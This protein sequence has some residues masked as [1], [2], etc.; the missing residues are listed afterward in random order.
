VPSHLRFHRG[1]GDLQNALESA[2][3]PAFFFVHAALDC[4][5]AAWLA[6]GGAAEAVAADAAAAPGLG[7][8]GRRSRPDDGAPGRGEGAPR[9]GGGGERWREVY[10]ELQSALVPCR[11]AAAA[12]AAAARAAPSS[13][14]REPQQQPWWVPA[15]PP[16]ATPRD[17]D[18]GG[19]EVADLLAWGLDSE[20]EFGRLLGFVACEGAAACERHPSSAVSCAPS[21]GLATIAHPRQ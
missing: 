15:A 10:A 9:G 3:D 16:S 11:E 12:D 4:N 8:R 7:A 14:S 20:A 1:A 6:A 2:N 5:F 18:V 13:V 17:P 19:I 21:S